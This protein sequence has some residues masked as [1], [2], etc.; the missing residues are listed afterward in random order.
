MRYESLVMKLRSSILMTLS[1]CAVS[2]TYAQTNGGTTCPTATQLVSH[3]IYTADTTSAPNWMTSFGPLV[4]PS[5]DVVY[6]FTTGTTV[7][8]EITPTQT[9]YAF[10]LYLFPGCAAGAEPPPVGATATIGVGIDLAG[11]GV[12]AGTTY[13]LAATGTAAGGATANGTVTF[14]TGATIPVTLQSFDVE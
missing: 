12:V 4:S 6:T 5:N 1:L 3:A 7:G 9:S 11:S 2:E 8:G 13:F 14:R 10:A